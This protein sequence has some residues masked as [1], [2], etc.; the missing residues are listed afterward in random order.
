MTVEVVLSEVG[1]NFI[2]CF[3][4]FIVANDFWFGLLCCGNDALCCSKV[5][6]AQKSQL[7]L[8][9]YA[10]FKKEVVRAKVNRKYVIGDS[11]YAV[12]D[13]SFQDDL[14]FIVSFSTNNIKIRVEI[15][16]VMCNR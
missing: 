11:Q 12:N 14:Y 15:F 9:L 10:Y 5:R 16:S 2:F 6:D 8:W 3:A 7:M 13:M 4:G 1:C